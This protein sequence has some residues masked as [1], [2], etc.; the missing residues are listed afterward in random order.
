MSSAE[1]MAALGKLGTATVHE[2]QGQ[3]GAM[4]S[5]IKPI[6][7][8]RRLMGRALTVDTR[9]DD[10]LMIHYAVT[11]AQQ[12]DV[13][14]V[15]AKGFTEGGPWGDILTEAAMAAG[16][17]GLIIDGVVRDADVIIEMGFPVFSRGLSI[18]GTNKAQPGRVNETIVCGGAVVH[19]GDFVFGD[20]DGV[21]VVSPSDA[22]DVLKAAEA[23]EA[24][25][26]AMRADIRAGKSTIELLGLGDKLKAMGFN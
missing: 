12:G 2:A 15:D 26:E 3:I 7:P 5:A 8:Q 13:L 10:N 24:K 1:T 9:P 11:K 6:D 19:P 22:E 14:V 25:E 16:I 23:R 21:V 17:T 20:R 4:T 18:K